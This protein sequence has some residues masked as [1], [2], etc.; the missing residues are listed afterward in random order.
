MLGS[1]K[2]VGSHGPHKVMS[3]H[4]HFG[5]TGT[6]RTVNFKVLLQSFLCNFIDV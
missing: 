4:V 2:S 5:F 3:S 6:D 1:F